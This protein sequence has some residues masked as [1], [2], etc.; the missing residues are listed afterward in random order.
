[1]KIKKYIVKNMQE[2]LRLIK[3]DLGPEAVIIS[4]YRLPRRNL[5]DFFTPRMMEVTAALDNDKR[6]IN[7]GQLRFNGSND[8]SAQ[9]LIQMLKEFKPIAT[10]RGLYGTNRD[11]LGYQRYANDGYFSQ[12]AGSR[13]P[14]DIILKNEGNFLANKE[15]TK[16][17]KKILTYLEIQESIVENLINGLVTAT[18]CHEENYGDDQHEFN[19]AYIKGKITRLLE[20]AYRPF[21]ANKIYTFVGPAG[22]GKTISLAKLATYYKMFEGKRVALV[23]VCQNGQRPNDIETLRYYGGLIDAPVEYVV[24]QDELIKSVQNHSNKDIIMVDTMGVNPK[25]TGKMLKLSNLLQAFDGKQ[26]IFL[27][28][29]STTKSADLMRAAGDYRKIGYSKLIFTKLDETD[30]CGSILNVVCKMGIPVAF[31]SYGQSVP[32][33]I[34]AVNPKKL[35]GLLLGGVDRFVEQGLQTR[36]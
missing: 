21:P 8:Q 6:I 32:D 3:E 31:V 30:T 29:S 36:T 15:I 4:S 27:V 9:K 14:F 18:G 19:L 35:A 16:H 12:V 5:F 1:M 13:V 10:G 24:S 25:V 26:D 20:P 34:A 7:Q 2:A 11:T 23:S 33:D 28:L 17:W 22:V